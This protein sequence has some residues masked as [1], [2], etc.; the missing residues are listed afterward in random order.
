MNNTS[1]NIDEI[2]SPVE[3]PVGN[4]IIS[5]ETGTYSGVTVDYYNLLAD[6]IKENYP[7]GYQVALIKNVN[8]L[9]ASLNEQNYYYLTELVDLNGDMHIVDVG[10]G[11]GQFFDFLQTKQEYK[12]CKCLGV[13]ISE[14]QIEYAIPKGDSTPLSF[15]P[16]DMDEFHSSEQYFDVYYFM[17]S[18]GYSKDFDVMV[19]SISTGLKNGGKVVIKNPLK[20]VIDEEKDKIYQEKFADIQKEY[21][22][23][24]NS[25][26]MLPNKETIE[27]TFLAN[28]FEL[29]K[30]EI[31]ECD[32]M[33][34]NNIFLNTKELIDSHPNYVSHITKRIP[35]DYSPNQ[36]LECAIFVFKKVEDIIKD[37]KSL[38]YIQKQYDQ[39][40]GS[41][42]MEESIHKSI[43]ENGVETDIVIIN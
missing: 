16:I 42:S 22:Y 40:T 5:D 11:T 13:D 21:G 17:E 19:K 10:C 15:F 7:Q 31:P 3:I 33:T 43:S 2:V 26:G 12:T 37:S 6:P 20:I 14:K 30:F 29:E 28:G 1:T 39:Y 32:I 8:H 18:I 23:D 4:D 34:Y 24:E 41:E 36:Y 35:E 27:N 25:L 9:D 38:P